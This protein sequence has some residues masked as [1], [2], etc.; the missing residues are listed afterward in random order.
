MTHAQAMLLAATILMIIPMIIGFK[1]VRDSYMKHHLW[2]FL[3]NEIIVILG[4]LYIVLTAAG[5]LSFNAYVAS[6][7]FNSSL[8]L[9]YIMII[10]T[11]IYFRALR[12]ETI[13][14]L[15]I[16]FCSFLLIFKVIMLYIS[17]LEVFR[18]PD[19]LFLRTA[20]LGFLALIPTIILIGLILYE[21]TMLY[22]HARSDLNKRPYASKLMS[23]YVLIAFL[24][25]FYYTGHASIYVS[26]II[27]YIQGLI[28]GLIALTISILF[29]HNPDKLVLLPI[30][31]KGLLLHTYGGLAILREAI[32]RDFERVVAL[33]SALVASI[34]GLET[35]IV[36]RERKN[37]FMINKL[38]KCT[39]VM[40][41]G[42]FVIGT[43]V[44]DRNNIVLRDIIRNI[45]KEYENKVGLVDEGMITNREIDAA[46]EILDGWRSF[47][48]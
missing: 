36:G 16:V 29:R 44:S 27:P 14:T 1:L 12:A 6:I 39:I 20:H 5:N 22:I 10:L 17:P 18:I 38:M 46:N 33:S 15:V 9:A 25:P 7:F 8:I 24:I 41:F 28:F 42:N 40:Y 43:I 45:V 23:T 3:L 19:N 4:I 32:S 2:P 37:F 47:L 35:A 31:I 13:S 30:R 34:I 26:I 11:Y 21:V 48:Y